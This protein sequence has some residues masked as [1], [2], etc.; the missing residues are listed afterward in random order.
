MPVMNDYEAT[1]AIRSLPVAWDKQTGNIERGF[2]DGDAMSYAWKRNTAGQTD[3]NFEGGQS[4]LWSGSG[5]CD[6]IVL[7]QGISVSGIAVSISWPPSVSGSGSS[8]SWQSQPVY[9][10]VAGASFNG[11]VVGGTAFSCTFSENGDVYVG[12]RIY[13]PTTTIKFSYFS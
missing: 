3:N 9:D 6:Y 11:L 10:N 2:V 1:A 13:R 7:N 12:S 4:S 8:A 5:N